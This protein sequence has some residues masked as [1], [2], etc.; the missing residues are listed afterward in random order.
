M[1]DAI[2][3]K[4]VV[5]Y[6]TL[7]GNTLGVEAAKA[8]GQ[9]LEKHPEFCKALW[10]NMFTSRLKTEIPQALSH[11]G[12]SLIMAN[13]HL[14]T[15]DLSDN[16][17]GPNGMMGLNE[18]LSSSVCYSL[19][20]LHMNNCGLGTGGGKMLADALVK[21]YENSLNNGAELKLEVLVIGRNRLEDK[22][23]MFI[24][25]LLST[26]CSLKE[27]VMPQNSICHEGMAYLSEGIKFNP[28]IEV[29][30]FNDNLIT[31]RGAI[32]LADAFED[33]PL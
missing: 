12:G 10:K 22:G 24:T 7:D 29:L 17:L 25:K 23:A 28:N 27:L 4:E 15:L 26:V 6:L 14:H 19:K 18:L 16:A 8:I 9:A 30:N 21:C 20:E 31:D 3:S 11:L 5:R 2:N 33:T 32:Y 13:A 1:V